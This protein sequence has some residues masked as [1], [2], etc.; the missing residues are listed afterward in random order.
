MAGLKGG[1]IT[2]EKPSKLTATTMWN[3]WLKWLPVIM[4]NE[5]A[6]SSLFSRGGGG[7]LLNIFVFLFWFSQVEPGWEMVYRAA[8]KILATCG[9]A[10]DEPPAKRQRVIM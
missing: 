7:L 8:G 9:V 2:V 6:D 3:W 10:D 4:V 1:R 5:A